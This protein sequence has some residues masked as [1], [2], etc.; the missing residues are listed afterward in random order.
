[1]HYAD[2]MYS[3]FT[4]NKHYYAAMYYAGT[5]NNVHY[6]G[7]TFITVTSV[8]VDTCEHAR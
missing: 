7:A 4:V 8:P 6:A 5:V 3:S 1:M 2:A